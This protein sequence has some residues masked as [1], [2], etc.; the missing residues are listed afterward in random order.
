MFAFPMPRLQPR[1]TDQIQ[2]SLLY[3]ITTDFSTIKKALCS[4]QSALHFLKKHSFTEMKKN[5]RHLGR[6]GR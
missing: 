5:A 1:L 4:S 2:S 6:D 3:T